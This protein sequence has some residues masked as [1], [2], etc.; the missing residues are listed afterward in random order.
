MTWDANGYLVPRRAE[1]HLSARPVSNQGIHVIRQKPSESVLAAYVAGWSEADPEKIASATAEGYELHD[2][3]VGR[4]S[5]RELPRYFT[6]LRARFP[7]A[8][9]HACGELGFTIRGPMLGASDEGHHRYWREAP[10]LG[11]TGDSEITVTASGITAET[12]AYDLNVACETLRSSR[13][14]TRS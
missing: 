9:T 8:G 10:L 12:V 2:P 14:A 13:Q 1:G 11:L 5:K 3:L 4:F 6:L 7:V